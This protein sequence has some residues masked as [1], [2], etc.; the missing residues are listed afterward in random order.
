M[1]DA[2]ETIWAQPCG[3]CSGFISRGRKPFHGENL[4]EY[5]RA[6]LHPAL[7]AAMELPEVIEMQAELIYLREMH[8]RG[9]AGARWEA[10]HSKDVWRDKVIAA[11]KEITT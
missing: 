11:T 10:N 7:S 6:D 9:I 1:S 5:R 4:T 2:P 8:K 3:K